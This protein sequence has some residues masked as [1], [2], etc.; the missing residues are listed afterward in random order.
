MVASTSWAGA[1]AKAAGASA[2]TVIAPANVQHPPDYDAKPSDL[3]AVAGADY[4]LYAE[5]DGFA[6]KIK[7]ATG[8]TGELV[9]VELENTPAKIRAEVTRLGA[10]FGTESAATTWLSSF[11]TEYAALSSG[12]KA[13]VPT[14]PPVVVSHLFMGYW[15]EFAGLQVQATYGPEPITPGQLAEL[16]AKKPTIVLANSHIPGANP[17]IPGAKRVDIVNFPADDLDLLGV[18]RT[19]AQ[20]LTAA[21]AG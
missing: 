21:V 8:G 16:T 19:N 10:M 7:E 1:L 13:K 11:D 20:R 6:A 17:E 5:F 3:A 9:P 4:I 12:V 18:F 14:T 15:G 2:V